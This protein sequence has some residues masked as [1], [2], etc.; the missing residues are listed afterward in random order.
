MAN[1]HISH[2]VHMVMHNC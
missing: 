1:A 2:Q